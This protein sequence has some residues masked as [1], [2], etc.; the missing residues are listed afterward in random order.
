MHC[1]PSVKIQSNNYGC[2][3]FCTI[4]N[5][6]D[7]EL[8]KWEGQEGWQHTPDPGWPFHVGLAKADQPRGVKNTWWH[9]IFA[10]QAEGC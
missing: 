1:K 4:H 7:T 5:Q 10:Q 2:R 3:F 6:T 9:S 8:G